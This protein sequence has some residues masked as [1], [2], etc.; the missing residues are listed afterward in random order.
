[1][2]TNYTMV[3]GLRDYRPARRG[4]TS[5][6]EENRICEHFGLTGMTRLELENL[7]DTVD[8]V[9]MLWLNQ[10]EDYLK[11]RDLADAADSIVSVINSALG[12]MY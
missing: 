6:E 3:L 8:L 12:S 9:Y 1:M 2:K 7:R 11:R 5:L 4:F 10:E